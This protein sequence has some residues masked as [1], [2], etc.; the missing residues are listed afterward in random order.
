MI[1]RRL[2]RGGG[3]RGEGSSILS[4]AISAVAKRP[5]ALHYYGGSG[6]FCEEVS[7]WRRWP[8]RVRVWRIA[9]LAYVVLGP[10]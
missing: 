1:S 6:E 5:V 2:G 4:L 8:W 10:A 9:P 7:W 3:R